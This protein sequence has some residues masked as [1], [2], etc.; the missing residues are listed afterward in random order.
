M[1]E[2]D[3]STKAIT[4]RCDHIEHC[5]ISGHHMDADRMRALV[6]ERD[7][8][9]ARERA[10]LD[11][12]K[13]QRDHLKELNAVRAER[14]QL[15]RERDEWRENF[16]ALEKAIVGD[17]GLSAMTVAV[18]ARKY[19][20]MYEA[21]RNEALEEAAMMAE[22]CRPNRPLHARAKATQIAEEIRALISEPAPSKGC[23]ECS[24]S[25]MRDSGGVQPWG[26][27]IDVPCGCENAPNSRQSVQEAADN[28]AKDLRSAGYFIPSSVIFE[29]MS[30][31]ESAS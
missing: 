1:T 4:D 23:P 6:T 14:D 16:R 13:H 29:A 8:A 10:L 24:G 26:E 19:R 11:S 5:T 15:R 9:L 28:L 25:G 27:H 3:T 18:Q 21:A 12:N 2:V 22:E 20:P 31:K 17:T 30:Q 7:Q